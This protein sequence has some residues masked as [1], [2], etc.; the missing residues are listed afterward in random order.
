M[1]SKEEL[2]SIAANHTEKLFPS[3]WNNFSAFNNL[4]SYEEIEEDFA[5]WKSFKKEVLIYIALQN[6][7]YFYT[8][9]YW[10]QYAEKKS[11]PSSKTYSYLFDSWHNAKK[12]VHGDMTKD[13]LK[14]KFLLHI[15]KEHIEKFKDKKNWDKYARLNKLPTLATYHSHFSD[16]ENVMKLIIDDQ[17]AVSEYLNQSSKYRSIT[18]EE[19]IYILNEHTDYLNNQEQWRGYSRIH[20]LPTVDLIR[21]H[22]STFNKMKKELAIDNRELEYSKEELLNIALK[23]KAFLEKNLWVI[24]SDMHQLPTLGAYTKAFDSFENVQKEVNNLEMKRLFFEKMDYIAKMTEQ[25]SDIVDLA[26]KKW[27]CIISKEEWEKNSEELG[28]PKLDEIILKFHSIKNVRKC[29]LFYIAKSNKGFFNGSKWDLYAKERNLPLRTRYNNQFF[30]SINLLEEYLNGSKLEKLKN[31]LTKIA[32]EHKDVFAK[33][34][35]KEWLDYAREHGL[36]SSRVYSKFFGSW[37]KAREEF[38]FKV[39]RV[40]KYTKEELIKVAIENIEHFSNSKMWAVFAKENGLPSVPAYITQFDSFPNAKKIIGINRKEEKLIRIA[41]ENK[42]VFEKATVKEWSE[43]ARENGLPASNVY[44]T[45]F[46]S[47]N[48]AR[49]KFGLNITKTKTKTK[50]YKYTKEVLTKVALENKEHFLTSQQWTIFAKEN[51]LPA[52][53]TY[54]SHFGSFANAQ[55]A[56]GLNTFIKYTE[57]KLVKVVLENKDVFEKATVKEWSEYARKHGLPSSN[58]YITFFGSWN[59]AREKFGLKTT[60]TKA[61]RYTKEVLAKV[62]LENKEHFLSAQWPIFAKENGLPSLPTYTNHFGSFTNARKAIGLNITKTS[63]NKYTKE[64]LVEVALE[65]KEHFKISKQWTIFAKEN[66]LPSKSTYV[67]HFGSF[68]NAQKEIGIKPIKIKRHFK[69]EELLEI[70]AENFVY[71][72]SKDIWNNNARK[73]NLPRYKTFYGRF[74]KRRDILKRIESYIENKKN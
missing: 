36:P 29:V 65:N 66:G 14:K 71:M 47:W 72:V 43:Y 19:L 15:A 16:W 54:V 34:T 63:P 59:K 67:S 32:F 52:K 45:C 26:S 61:N 10:D 41:L 5:S 23:H 33:S 31:E 68:A 62:A 28:L 73:N 60:K 1:T 53:S 49:E 22:F 8:N 21:K 64:K 6:K 39:K 11:F 38:G 57:E 20:D 35:W 7:D 42:D 44:I 40:K 17:E 70:G 50:A 51:G 58:V 48:K 55:K 56:I 18:K 37:N 4:P 25:F 13:E 9:S 27:E 2:I 3:K 69:D 74:G 30:Y 12:I 46:G 24:Y